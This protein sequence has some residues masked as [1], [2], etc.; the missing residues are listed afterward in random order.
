VSVLTPRPGG[1]FGWPGTVARI[2][3]R[4]ERAIEAA[5]WIARARRELRALPADRVIAHWAVPC[6]FPIGLASR[7]PLEIV[8][9]GGDV[10]LLLALPARV[11]R[12]LV[13]MLCARA[14]EWAFASQPLLDSLAVTLDADG[15]EALARVAR[16]RAPPL[17]M[18][19]VRAGIVQKRSTLAGARVAVSVGR[20]VASKRVDRALRFIAERERGTTL[21]VVGDGPERSRL[22]ALAKALGVDARFVGAV[23]RE[24]ALAWIGAADLLIHA[25]EAEGLSTVIREAE[26]L[27]TP[28]TVL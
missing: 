3:A 28:V 15:R 13:G 7:A 27:G 17:E 11:R 20:L 1:A 14:R 24:E 9:H 6:A 25:S 2:R 4:P 21:V 8:S 10:R 22:T 19:D 12:G 23:A 26:A 18:P 16:V 5:R